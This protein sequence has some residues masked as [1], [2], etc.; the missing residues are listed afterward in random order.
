VSLRLHPLDTKI[1][2]DLWRMKFQALAIALLI[3]A[4]VAVTVMAYSTQEALRAARDAYYSQTRFADVFVTMKRAPLS[5]AHRAAEIAGVT[6]TDPRIVFGGL[7][8]IAGLQRPA[9][10]QL[11]SLPRN[12]DTALNRIVI[13]R[14]RAPAP[15][16]L[17]EAI[18]LQSFLDAAKITI[19]E[20]LEVTA[21]G[22]L[23]RFR[24]VGAA[25]SAEFIYVPS[26]AS[27][28][29][30]DAHNGVLWV[31]RPALEGAANMEGAF[32][33]LALTLAPGAQPKAIE[34]ALTRLYQPYGLRPV[35]F[36]ADQ[37]SHAFIEGEFEELSRSGVIFPPI[38]LIVAG[39]L[40][41]M[42]MMRLTE[43][44]REEIGLLKAF[45]YT[46]AE[47]ARPYALLALL[48]G[49]IGAALG[50]LFGAWL[51]DAITDLY[52]RYM[53]FPTLA[54]RF[55]VIAFSVAAAAGIGAALAGALGAVRK[56]A[57]LSPAVAMSPPR[58]ARFHAAWLERLPL[59]KE[60]GVVTRL[61]LRNLE[62]RPMRAAFT[63]C[64]LAA[65][66]ALLVGTQ[67]LFGAFD[68]IM[69]HNFYQRQ[70]FSH[71]ISF[72]EPRGAD[73][74]QDVRQLPGVLAARML[75]T[76]DATV[77]NGPIFD[78]ISLIG[79]DPDDPFLRP[80]DGAG[81]P[82]PLRA[83]GI[84][85]T[86]ALARKLRLASGDRLTL[87][88]HEQRQPTATI[89]VT[90]AVTEYAGLSAYMDRRALNRLLGEGDL[91]NAAQVIVDPAQTTS[92]YQAVV[93]T[94]GIAGAISRDDT[95]RSFRDVMAQ[96]FRTSRI[97]YA[98][99][100]AVIAFGVA[101]NAGRI[102]FSERARDLATLEV[103]GFTHREIAVLQL[104]EQALLAVLA[105]PVGLGFGWVLAQLIT[106][107]YQRDEM[108]I[109]AIVDESTLAISLLV[110]A[111]TIIIV[112]LL[113][114]YRIWRLDLVAVLKTRE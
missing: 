70:R 100:A 99:F 94:P 88:L 60:F 69:D 90:G 103:L 25:L 30:D 23:L 113:I 3:A 1:L 95:I 40:V 42:V 109:P 26:A 82:L 104:G 93:A 41:Q 54:P 79:L 5:L 73:A 7:S 14:G 34:Q 19:G 48:I 110:Y 72:V 4:G 35:L 85:L 83:Q 89:V 77:S 106:L 76:V 18:A 22:R 62:R 78:R 32:N 46:D 49:G 56:A 21:G 16:A 12:E 80:L 37:P 71:Q 86:E 67:F 57:R 28:M 102:A 65:S 53:R 38:F 33:A 10:L 20:E 112:F 13:V 66:I 31:T 51:A 50:A 111:A 98:L 36:R 6:G 92:F 9:Q 64:G 43:V 105:I 75:R 45:G 68:M 81:R 84:L 39:A 29:P 61:V 15:G 91:S 108:R 47:A 59:L 17:D 55:H 107:A 97:T 63:I 96:A 2:R 52:A 24:I 58:P 101:Y 114:G 27:I 44:Q 74:A 11:V 8:K 87:R